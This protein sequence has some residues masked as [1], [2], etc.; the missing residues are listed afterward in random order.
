MVTA[1]VISTVRR[2]VGHLLGSAIPSSPLCAARIS[3]SPEDGNARGKHH[4]WCKGFHFWQVLLKNQSRTH[5]L[6]S[7]Q[8]NCFF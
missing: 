8:S 3:P 2:N 6:S 1:A 4:S 5:P 7:A